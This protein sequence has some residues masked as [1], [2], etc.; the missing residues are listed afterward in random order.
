M[1]INRAVVL[2]SLF[3]A[4]SSSVRAEPVSVG[5]GTW[6]WGNERE[7]LEGDPNRVLLEGEV[8]VEVNIVVSGDVVCG[9]YSGAPTTDK[10]SF[11]KFV[12]SEM[13]GV[14]TLYHP[15]GFTGDDDDIE[16]AVIFRDGP[17]LKWI[18]TVK[19][20]RYD[21][22]W[23]NIDIPPVRAKK[24]KIIDLRRQCDFVSKQFQSITDQNAQA[25]LDVLGDN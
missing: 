5:D 2:A 13:R 21:Y 24:Q 6:Y 23:G 10:M 19:G 14:V 25:A 20:R 12:G 15:N 9:D 7:I 8:N 22:L 11:F 16:Q 17:N 4:T 18:D 3:I 1:K